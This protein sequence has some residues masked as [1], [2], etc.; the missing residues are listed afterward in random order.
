MKFLYAEKSFSLSDAL[1]ELKKRLFRESKNFISRKLYKL[2]SKP[3]FYA[4]K[5]LLHVPFFAVR[6][7]FHLYKPKVT[8]SLRTAL[9]SCP[10]TYKSSSFLHKPFLAVRK[11]F[12]FLQTKSLSF[13]QTF[14][15]CPQKTPFSRTKSR[16]FAQTF[17]YY[18]PKHPFSTLRLPFAPPLTYCPQRI[19]L[20]F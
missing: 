18:H 14:T 8:E 3:L 1:H 16:L 17:L 19:Q 9:K 12:P 2:H 10:F 13:A 11:N 7:N 4:Q 5:L 15:N 20:F 6:K